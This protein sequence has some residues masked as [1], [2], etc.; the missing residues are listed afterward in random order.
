M[1]SYTRFPP[2]IIAA[3]L[4]FLI[5]FYH[6]FNVRNKNTELERKARVYSEALA[7]SKEK[8]KVLVKDALEKI[9][10]KDAEIKRLEEENLSKHTALG[11]ANGQRAEIE[12][13]LELKNEEIKQLHLLA[14]SVT[15]VYKLKS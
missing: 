1:P 11:R 5:T 9:D 3:G 10:K 2:Y 14:V 15:I 12:K 6:V 8:N 7:V 4:L 13:K